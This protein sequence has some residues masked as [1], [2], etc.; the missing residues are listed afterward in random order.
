MPQVTIDPSTGS[1][2]HLQEHQV[3]ITAFDDAMYLTAMVV[4]YD[5][6]GINRFFLQLPQVMSTNPY[7]MQ[8]LRYGV[9]FGSM[10]EL[11]RWL[12]SFGINTDA[13]TLLSSLVS[14]FQGNVST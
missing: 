11:R 7:V 13:S 12:N 5:Y 6:T 8:A 4:V 9:M 14:H 1:Q 2:V 10:L 3:L